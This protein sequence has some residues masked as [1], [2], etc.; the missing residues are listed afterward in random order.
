M[1]GQW[2]KIFHPEG[3]A[4][5]AKFMAIHSIVDIFHTKNQPCGGARGQVRRLPN[6][7]I[8]VHL[9]VVKIFL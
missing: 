9:I 8:A 5:V 2:V 3:N 7:V 6:V 1:K 4:N